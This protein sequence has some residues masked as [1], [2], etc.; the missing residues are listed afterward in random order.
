MTIWT[1]RRSSLVFASSF[2]LLL[3]GLALIYV[4]LA[5]H[6]GTLLAAAILLIAGAVIE[7]EGAMLLAQAAALGFGLALLAAALA[8]R[9]QTIGT[10]GRSDSQSFVHLGPV[11]HAVAAKGRQERRAR[12]DRHGPGGFPSGQPGTEVMRRCG[13]ARMVSPARRVSGR[14]AVGWLSAAAA[15]LACCASQGADPPPGENSAAPAFPFRRIFAP[16]DRVA[17]WPRG[18]T[19]YLPIESAEFERLIRLV[20]GAG[21]ASELGS[22]QLVSANYEAQ[23]VDDDTLVGNFAWQVSHGAKQAALISLD[24]AGIAL[25]RA[26]WLDGT[27]AAV[28]NG[29]DGRLALLVDRAGEVRGEWSLR[30]E[31]TAAGS[32]TFKIDLPAAVCSRL[33]CDLPEKMTVSTDRGVVTSSPGAPAG[34]RR[35]QLEL[36]GHSRVRFRAL[37]EEAATERRQSTLLRESLTYE[38]SKRGIDVSAALR[39][40]VHSEPLQR[41]FVQLDPGLQLLAARYGDVDI[42]WTPS[43][44]PKPAPANPP[45]RPNKPPAKAPAASPPFQGTRV[46]LDFPEPISGTGRTLHLVAQAAWPLGERKRL[47]GIRAEDIFWQE[48]TATLLVPRPL[49][50]EQIVTHGCRQSKAATLAA[51]GSG[52]TV[53]LQYFG[54]DATVDVRVDQP[55]Q[56]LKIDC[57]TLVDLGAA[58]M[59]AQAVARLQ[60]AQGDRFLVRA[61]LG[62]QWLIDSVESE[63]DNVADWGVTSVDDKSRQLVIR[64]KHAITPRRPVRLYLKGH[65]ATAVGE[66]IDGPALPMVRFHGPSGV[67][68]LSV[69][70]PES[71][72]LQT[73]HADELSRRD[74]TRLSVAEAAVFT[75]APSGLLFSVDAGLSRLVVW[76]ANR[77]PSYAG[78]IA[79]D[80]AVQGK[81]LN[82]TFIFRCTPQGSA[83]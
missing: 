34:F 79:V 62:S 48:G 73:L 63:S 45:G 70:A 56:R 50:L 4:P 57:G 72:E 75:E 60:V 55:D 25:H 83:S 23:L 81:T 9:Q 21:A 66:R 54:A 41:I 3:G 68:L 19:N 59:T 14:I 40:D 65:R 11:D 67:Q 53:E 82:Q 71:Y 80:V 32:V 26:T 74:P 10:S 30:G 31:R 44:A 33:R 46:A 78:E 6:P 51:P 69:R 39:L 37:A 76:L 49:V 28:G 35:W 13:C 17:D 12:V 7:P 5:R 15:L 64:L 47:P 22:A 8:A 20:E 52:D 36:G 29:S 58:E 61:E 16:A 43:P 27:D 42:P 18:Q 24:P 38:F 2:A 1:A 77:R